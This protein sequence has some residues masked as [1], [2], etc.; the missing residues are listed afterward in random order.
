[1]SAESAIRVLTLQISSDMNMRKQI[2]L[3]K[4]AWRKKRH[5]EYDVINNGFA[6]FNEFAGIYGDSINDLD[7]LEVF[8]KDFMAET[9]GWVNV[10]MLDTDNWDCIKGY[11]ID[12]EKRLLHLYWRMK[13]ADPEEMEMRQMVLPIDMYGLTIQFKSVQFIRDKKGVCFAICINGYTIPESTVSKMVKRFNP[14]K[15]R[16]D[17]NS[18]FFST[19]Y[20]RLDTDPTEEMRIMKTPIKS[21]WIIPKDLRIH[22]QK[23]KE[24]LY[25]LNLQE[26]EDMVNEAMDDCANSIKK[27]KRNQA[28]IDKSIKTAGNQI[29]QACENLFKLIMCFY[30]EDYNFKPDSYDNRLLAD[31][32]KPIKKHVYTSADDAERLRK[33]ARI[34]NDCSHFNGLPVSMPDLMEL[35]L[36]TKYYIGDFRLKVKYGK[37]F[38]NTEAPTTPKLPSPSDFIKENFTELNFGAT[39]LPIR[40]CTNGKMSYMLSVNIPGVAHSF[41]IEGYA[42]CQDGHIHLLQRE[43]LSNALLFWERN[44]AIQAKEAILKQISDECAA[45]GYDGENLWKYLSIEIHAQK[46]AKPTHLFTEDEIRAVMA[47]GDDNVNNRLVIDEDGYAHLIQDTE[48]GHLYPVYQECWG[49][50]ENAVGAASTLSQCYES[51]VACVNCWL[52]YLE[53]GITIYADMYYD[54]SNIDAVI[55]RVKEYY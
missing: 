25:M 37:K 3:W 49:A 46:E 33:I 43:D 22:P 15:S 32:T 13:E 53:A 26:C 38:P 48:N 50:G 6:F 44:E 42:L 24:L 11:S 52:A 29:R 10:D 20:I 34:A 4:R 17:A 30:H 9:G 40:K 36:Q 12:K 28:A 31:A 5:P 41:I 8:M 55:E 2:A 21:F 39:V 1:M 51:Y 47:T 7:T 54:D 35:I 27:N 19:D 14:S 23:S 18:S 45:N 16:V